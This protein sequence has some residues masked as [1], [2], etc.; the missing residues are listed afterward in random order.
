MEKGKLLFIIFMIV[1]ILVVFSDNLYADEVKRLIRDLSKKYGVDERVILGIAFVESKFGKY[2]VGDRNKTWD[3]Q[4]YGVMQVKLTTAKFVLQRI[5]K[6][7][8]T[9]LSDEYLVDRLLHDDRFNIEIGI[10]YFKYLL[11]QVGH[12]LFRA[13]QAY[14]RGLYGKTDNFNYVYKVM[15]YGFRIEKTKLEKSLSG[16]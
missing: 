14:N 2:K 1:V 5:L 9:N 8:I 12:N 15:R 4:S 13:V 10:L 7:D 3:K 11:K 16:I 6:Q